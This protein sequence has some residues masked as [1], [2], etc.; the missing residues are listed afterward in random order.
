MHSKGLNFSGMWRGLQKAGQKVDALRWRLLAALARQ[1]LRQNPGPLL[2]WSLMSPYMVAAA[3]AVTQLGVPD[4]L[5]HRP[6]TAE[7]L[8]ELTGSRPDY[9]DRV[10]RALAASGLLELAADGRYTLTPSGEWLCDR[11]QESFHSLALSI[12]QAMEWFPLLH[13]TIQTGESP[14]RIKYGCSLWEHYA[15]NPEAGVWFDR[16]MAGFTAT[17]AEAIL[18]A[19]DFAPFKVIADVGGGSGALLGALLKACP[20][21]RGILYD[22]PEVVKGALQ[23][24]E[25]A[26]VAG[27]CE[28]RG[29][30]FRQNVPAGA[31]LY[32]VKHV[33]HDW[34]DATVERML[35]ALRAAMP[36]SPQGRLLVIEGLLDQR[37]SE[38][39]AL[40]RWI[41]IMQ[42]VGTSGRARTRAELESLLQRA[43]FEVVRV[44]ATRVSDTVIV[45]A[46]PR[47]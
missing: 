34:D 36:R 29:G 15:N 22:R 46:R 13:R 10:L 19:Y 42:M 17:H 11:P 35:A 43:G 6:R 38:S 12:G 16:W 24:L 39:E 2:F 37:R 32:V 47:A 31:D 5:R 14:V 28:I 40:R 8:A 27:R 18:E 45:E 33:L 21:S 25:A 41:D 1:H 20:R 4:L 3:Y 30:D 26:G 44:L 7:E 23:A 9:L